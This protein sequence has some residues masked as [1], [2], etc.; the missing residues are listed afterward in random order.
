MKSASCSSTGTASAC[1]SCLSNG[2]ACSF[3]S[4]GISSEIA[5]RSRL[6]SMSRP[7]MYSSVRST[8][9]GAEPSAVPAER[10][11]GESGRSATALALRLLQLALPVEHARFRAF[12]FR[13]RDHAGRLVEARQA[14]VREDVVGAEL[15]ELLAGLDRLH[16]LPHL[17]VGHREAVPGV[18]EGGIERDGLVV[19]GHRL[20]E[21][22][23]AEEIDGRVVEVLLRG[24]PRDPYPIAAGG[25]KHVESVDRV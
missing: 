1:S 21:L 20:V 10:R 7:M 22:A 4:T 14:R 18:D 19:A 5:I 17:A 3:V 8:I 25:G 24:H 6:R 16:V 13:L 12:G 9:G 15:A 23:V 11:V 2:C